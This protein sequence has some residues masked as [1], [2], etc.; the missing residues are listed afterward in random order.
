MTM[1]A[2]AST[3]SS[4]R[5]QGRSVAVNGARWILLNFLIQLV[6]MLRLWH[7]E[8]AQPL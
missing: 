2:D 4:A 6:A 5:L 1:A 7:H 8:T 3:M